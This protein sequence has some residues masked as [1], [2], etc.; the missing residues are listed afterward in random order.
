MPLHADNFLVSGVFE[1]E[2]HIIRRETQPHPEEA[3]RL[4]SFQAGHLLH[5]PVPDSYP[6]HS[7]VLEWI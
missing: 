1:Q 5:F 6:F 4:E 7:S 2:R 3:R